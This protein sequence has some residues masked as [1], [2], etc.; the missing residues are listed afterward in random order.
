MKIAIIGS[1][2]LTV[3]N[4]GEYIPESCTEIV[5]GGAKGIDTY[6]AEYAQKLNLKLTLFLPEYHKYGKVAPLIRNKLIVDYSDLVIALWDGSSSGT[7]SVI[8]Y[9]EKVGKK[10]TVYLLKK[11]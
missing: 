6:A 3:S 7:K 11:R 4:I 2:N 5:T 1:R 8:S 9:C 10:I